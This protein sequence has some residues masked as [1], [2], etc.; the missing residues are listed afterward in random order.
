LHILGRVLSK[1]LH[2]HAAA[3]AVFEEV[4]RLDQV[5]DYGRHY[6]AYNVDW[7]AADEAL[8]E[9][10][11]KRAVELNPE[12]PWWWS[13]WINF[14]ITTGKLAQARREWNRANTALDVRECGPNDRVWWALHLWVA[15]LLLHRGQLEF[16]RY[17][18]GDVH[19]EPRRKDPQFVA[20]GHL[21]Q[22][23]DQAE[24]EESVFPWCVSPDDW[25]TKPYPHLTFN[26][27]V[28]NMPLKRWYPARVV[29]V[30]DEAV[31]LIVGKKP[32]SSGASPTYGRVSIPRTQF[33][34]ACREVSS[35]KI[36]PDR[37]L[38]LA[39]YGDDDVVD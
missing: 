33:D 20:I 4:V 30:D 3:A 12:H 38:E 26:L 31:W 27:E 5:D 34:A 25:W 15:R 36:E 14:L 19:E 18:L 28:D 16:G 23:L 22:F 35:S 29:E 1:Q 11:Y 32:E 7:D 8:A 9:R 39:F 10:E 2:D 37:Y 13:R 24:D 6:W 21:L 17:V